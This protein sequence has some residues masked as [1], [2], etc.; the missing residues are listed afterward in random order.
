MRIAQLA[1]LSERV[2]PPAYGGTELVVSLLTEELIRR[3]H[4]VTLFASGDSVTQANLVSVIPESLRSQ[5]TI[6][7][8]RW[9]AYDSCQLLELKRQQHKFDIVHNHM[10]WQALP[11]VSAL[12]CPVVTTNHNPVKDYCRPIYAEYGQM[13]YVAISDSYRRLNYPETL[14]YVATVYNGIAMDDFHSCDKQARKHLLFLGRV[15]EDKGT[16]EAIEIARRLGLPLKIGGKIDLSDQAYFEAKVKPHIDGANVEY[17]GEVDFQQKVDLLGSA[18]AVV[19]PITFAEPFGLVMAESLASG[20]PVLALDRGSVREVVTDG[21]TG[22]VADSVKQL[23]ERFPEIAT[24]SSQICID[25]VRKLF[26][27]ERMVDGYESVY[28]AL[29]S[30]VKVGVGKQV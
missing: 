28:H 4:E 2:P 13:P 1:P 14:N 10:G 6:P 5:S 19:Y 17:L 26:S 30:A 7:H 9:A 8:V 11:L 29:L 23:V 27:V 16:A 24:I 15:C 18:I 22:I 20:T 25:R 12:H 3:G 21:E